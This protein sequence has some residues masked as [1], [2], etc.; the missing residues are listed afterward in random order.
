MNIAQHVLIG[1]IRLYQA[2][3]SPALLGLLGPSARC[4]FNPS[5]SE[6]ARE[7]IRL[8]GAAVGCCLAAGRL[9]RCHPWGKWGEDPPP[10]APVRFQARRLKLRKMGGCHGS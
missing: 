6:Y 2:V 8:H 4:R 3:I 5:C 10:A 9:C 1:V 7:S